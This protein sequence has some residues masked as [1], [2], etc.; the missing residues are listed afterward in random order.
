[1]GRRVW[2]IRVQ[3]RSRGMA[4]IMAFIAILLLVRVCM[5]DV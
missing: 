5:P 2:V 3:P 1:M 4:I